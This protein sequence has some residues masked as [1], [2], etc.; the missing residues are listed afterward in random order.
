MYKERVRE[1]AF[2]RSYALVPD[3]EPG[4]FD[5][6]V[7]DFK[8]GMWTTTPA[9]PKHFTQ[10]GGLSRHEW[11]EQQIPII[12]NERVVQVFEECT[13]HNDYCFGIGLHA[14][15]D[16]PYLT[17]AAVNDFIRRFMKSEAMFHSRVPLTYSHDEIERCLLYTSPSPR[18]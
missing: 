2:D 14:T 13:L 7:K 3:C 8:T 1:L 16:V 18:D 10:F 12:A 6:M 15:I 4:I 11:V 5:A 9:D 17:V